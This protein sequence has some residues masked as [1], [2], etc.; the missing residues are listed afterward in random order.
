MLSKCE[1]K[2]R[3]LPYFLL[4]ICSI[5]MAQDQPRK[6][7]GSITL[8]DNQVVTGKI[9]V[10][11]AYDLVLIEYRDSIAVFPAHKISALRYFDEEANINRKFVA[12]LNETETR[13]VPVIFEMVVSG[14]VQVLRRLKSIHHEET[15]DADGY[16]YYSYFNGNL[17]NLKDFAGKVYPEIQSL[18][19]KEFVSSR[20]ISPYQMQDVFSIIKHFNRQYSAGD[21]ASI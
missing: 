9:L 1:V 19:L 10:H 5:S 3:L 4:L 7:E 15:D 6:Y 8:S 17:H 16:N 11:R 14:K 12:I 18:S 13:R 20:K 2:P 21:V